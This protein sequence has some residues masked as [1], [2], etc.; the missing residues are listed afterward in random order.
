MFKIMKLLESQCRKQKVRDGDFLLNMLSVSHE[1]VN[2]T[3]TGLR[4]ALAGTAQAARSPF[5]RADQHHRVCPSAG[6]RAC[7]FSSHRGQHGSETRF[8]ACDPQCQL[9]TGDPMPPPLEETAAD[10][11]GPFIANTHITST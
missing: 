1:P 4:A 7:P 3:V 6:H 8:L 10:R 5:A 2:S 9:P 11:M